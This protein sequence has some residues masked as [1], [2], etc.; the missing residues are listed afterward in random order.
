MI[1]SHYDGCIPSLSLLLIA[2]MLSTP[3]SRNPLHTREITFQGYAREDGLWDI[4]AHLR[5]FKFH[6]FT[7]GGKTWEPG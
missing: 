1:C 4:E 2:A 5:D 3:A 6:P 7:T